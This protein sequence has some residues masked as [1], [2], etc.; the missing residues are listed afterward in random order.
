MDVIPDLSEVVSFERGDV[1][2]LVR[3]LP[4]RFFFRYPRKF[5]PL[6]AEC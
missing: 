6:I 5:K 3:T 4:S 1:V 2:Q